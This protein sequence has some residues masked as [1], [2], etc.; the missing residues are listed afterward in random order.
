VTENPWYRPVRVADDLA[1]DLVTGWIA[2][3]DTPHDLVSDGCVDVL[4]ID[5]GAAWVCGPETTGW[6]FFTYIATWS[7]F[8][9]AAFAID[10]FSR[11][12]VGWRVAR[13]M[14]TDLPFARRL[15]GAG[16]RPQPDIHMHM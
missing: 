11:M 9:Y 4:W 15:R 2:R 10:V 16:N 5:N 12:I 13:T 3:P 7:G 8:A 1:H 6:T 14:V